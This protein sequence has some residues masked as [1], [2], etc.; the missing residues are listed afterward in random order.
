MQDVAT[1]AGV[2]R[3]LVSI[4]FRDLPGASAATR[5]RVR[6]V[7]AEIGYRPD[8]R[9]RLLSRRQTRLLGVTFVVAHEFHNDVVVELYAAAAAQDYELVLSGITPGREEAQA[10]QELVSLRCD[11]L[12]L[13]GPTM[14]AAEL[15]AVGRL[16]PTVSV[17]RLVSAEIASVG[18]DDHAGARLATEHLIELGH[19][20]IVHLDGGRAPGA[21]Q[22]RRG[23]QHAMR[24]AGLA[25]L[26]SIQS[27]G[28]SE[29]HGRDAAQHVL[30]LEK[31]VR[32]TA[33]FAFNDQ[34]AAGYLAILERAGVRVPEDHSVVGFDNSRIARSLLTQLTTIGQNLP[35]L[36]RCA[37]ERAVGAQRQRSRR[38]LLIAPELVVRE[39][40]A[41]PTALPTTM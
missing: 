2:S 36:S 18:T 37:V 41:R 3:A 33:T 23:Y 16:T 10:V 30:C 40:T 4:V 26:I 39:S 9:A 34:C 35:E 11:G 29:D 28:L 19:T 17:A 13:I 32:P 6:A 25:D 5:E 15:D 1:R 14:K 27:G 22:R 7:A 8:H 20:R 31:S 21:P 24:A 12:I 38:N